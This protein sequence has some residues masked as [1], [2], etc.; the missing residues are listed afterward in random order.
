M[1]VTV[2]VLLTGKELCKAIQSRHLFE[3]GHLLEGGAKN[4]LSEN[5]AMR[6]LL[7]E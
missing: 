3:E 5:V 6:V 4:H 2:V 1:E 7:L